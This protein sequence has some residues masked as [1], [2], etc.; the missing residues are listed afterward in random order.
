MEVIICIIYFIWMTFLFIVLIYKY[1]TY[2]VKKE[3]P[4]ILCLSIIFTLITDLSTLF[5]KYYNHEKFF[6][7]DFIISGIFG[8]LSYISYLYRGVTLY[9]NH[10]SQKENLYRVKKSNFKNY[11]LLGF[12]MMFVFLVGYVL[13]I[14][15]KYYNTK[16]NVNDWQYIPI[17][18]IM[19]SFSLLPGMNNLVLMPL[20]RRT[21]ESH[22]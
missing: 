13:N 12:F 7:I 11:F 1:N 16:F 19:F 20:L 6:L 4:L 21:K 17:A 3:Q 14:S 8:T 18:I 10:I 9:A 15:I 5:L 2:N 22:H